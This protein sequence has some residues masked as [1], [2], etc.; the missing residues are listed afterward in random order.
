ML[1]F[2]WNCCG[3]EEDLSLAPAWGVP[4]QPFLAYA[5]GVWRAAFDGRSRGSSAQ[6][7]VSVTGSGRAFLDLH[8]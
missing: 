5:L 4:S 3:I 7:L 2:D 6:E 8:E 1:W